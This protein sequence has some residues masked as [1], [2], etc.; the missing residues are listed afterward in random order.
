MTRTT[1]ASIV[2][3]GAQTDSR[4]LGKIDVCYLLGLVRGDRLW[5]CAIL[6]CFP[7]VL[8]TINPIVPNHCDRRWIFHSVF[9]LRYIGGARLRCSELELRSSE[10]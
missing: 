8:Y 1:E 3:A 4:M 2:R 6:A 10:Y 9:S 5:A 7:L